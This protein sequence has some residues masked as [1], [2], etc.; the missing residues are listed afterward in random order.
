M[1]LTIDEITA[2][3]VD[4]CKQWHLGYPTDDNWSLADWSNAMCGEAGEAANVVKKWRR[5]QTGTSTP[6][7]PSVY[8]LRDALAD[9]IADVFLY[10]NLLAV[11]ADIDMDAAIARKFNVVSERQGF[12]R[13]LH[14]R[15]EP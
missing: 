13:R 9:E 2:A 14:V 8:E 10:L 5:H 11:K 7:D 1:S 4:R 3:N 12:P 6:R 15:G